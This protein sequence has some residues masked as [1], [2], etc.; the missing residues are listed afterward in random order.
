MAVAPF[1]AATLE[2]FLLDGLRDGT[3][4]QGQRLGSERELAERFGTTRAGLRS[5]LVPLQRRGLVRRVTGRGGG[6][7]V[8]DFTVERDL[9]RIVSVVEYLRRQGFETGTRVLSAALTAADD[10]VAD[11][12]AIAEGAFVVELVRVRSAN[13][14]P[15]VLEH[16]RLPADRFPGLLELPL[17]GSVLE[18]LE[19]HYDLEQGDVTEVIEA[20]NATSAAARVLDV[21]VGA[22]L[23]AVTRTAVATRGFPFEYS[24]DLFRGDHTR[25]VVRAPGGLTATAQWS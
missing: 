6:T 12:L 14:V 8:G 22:A 3:L 18:L 9:S 1:D 16:S 11:A 21:A 7:F 15:I 23:I 17:G 4:T 25:V 2:R 20:V 13:G 5:A 24:Q 19:Q 10:I